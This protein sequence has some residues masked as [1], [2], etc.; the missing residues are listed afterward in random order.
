MEVVEVLDDPSDHFLSSVHE[1]LDS[2][3]VLFFKISLDLLHVRLNV[4][5]IVG[6]AEGS[7]SV[8]ES[9]DNIKDLFSLV[10]NS[11]IWVTTTEFVSS[12]YAN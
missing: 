5:G 3:G 12:S 4:G 7:F 8:V 1:G 9:I 10:I 6:L 2:F 11:L